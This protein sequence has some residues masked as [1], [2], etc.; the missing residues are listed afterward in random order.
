MNGFPIPALEPAFEV[1]VDLGPLEDH[2]DTRAG[3]RRV[4]PITGGEVSGGV[5]G[6]ILPGGADYQV[7]RADGAID[8]DARYTLVTDAG[9]FVLI[10]ARGIRSGAREVL[11]SLL[12]GEVVAPSEY[13]FRTV[14]TLETSAPEL[15]HLEHSVFVAVAARDAE[16]VRYSAYRVG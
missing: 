3:H 16:R 6:R 9:S 10:H 14:L 7:L 12:H 15:A 5:S 2:G 13:Y 8:V 1:V 11:E 4:V